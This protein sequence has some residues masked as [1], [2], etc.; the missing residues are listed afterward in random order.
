MKISFNDLSKPG[1]KLPKAPIQIQ[2]DE[3]LEQVKNLTNQLHEKTN[4][5]TELQKENA[6]IKD[7][8]AK[9]SST[10]RDLEQEVLQKNVQIMEI[11]GKNEHLQ[12]EVVQKDNAID[13]LSNEIQSQSTTIIDLRTNLEA[14][15]NDVVVVLGDDF[16]HD[17]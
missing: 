3:L 5:I 11:T 7:V 16:Q 13:L 6:L 15:E 8:V 4:L 14:L 2:R 12:N 10:I 17:A 9:T 1:F